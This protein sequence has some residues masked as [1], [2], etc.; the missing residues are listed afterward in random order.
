MLHSNENERAMAP[1]NS[2]DEFHKHDVEQNV[3][4]TKEDIVYLYTLVYKV[5]NKVH[6]KVEQSIVKSR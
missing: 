6:K 2:I 5:Q 3:A 1:P 4:N